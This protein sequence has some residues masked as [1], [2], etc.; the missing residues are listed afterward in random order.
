M[1]IFAHRGASG[2]YPENTILAFK[3]AIDLDIKAIELDVHKSK[4]GTLVVIHDEDIERTFKGHGLVKNYIYDELKNFKCRKFEFINNNLC[5][6]P[7]LRD[8]L[9]LVKDY[10]IFL[11]IEAKTDLIHYDL[12]QD[13]INLIEEYNLEDNILIS[14]FNHNCIEIFKNINP[15]IKYANLYHNK[16]DYVGFDNVVEHAKYSGIYSINLNHQLVDKDL[17]NLAHNNNLKVFVYTVNT[18][19]LMRNMIKYGVDGIFSDYPDL[20]REILES[21]NPRT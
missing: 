9:I 15:N 17:V 7:T 13:V 18:P 14:S 11:N 3:K 16:D 6:I 1:K 5:N 21:I 12:E 4:D 19:N 2:D 20:M 10:G 8:V